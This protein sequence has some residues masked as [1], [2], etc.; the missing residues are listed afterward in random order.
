MRNAS[1]DFVT[2]GKLKYEKPELLRIGTLESITRHA[3]HG[4]ATDQAFP[5]ETPFS[6]LQFSD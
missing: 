3:A 1:S 4:Y 5:A 6:S 2:G